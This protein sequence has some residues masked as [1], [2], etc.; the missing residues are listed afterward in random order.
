[1]S[2]HA[3][4]DAAAIHGSASTSPIPDVASPISSSTNEMHA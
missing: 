4:Y 3:T 1:M 2:F